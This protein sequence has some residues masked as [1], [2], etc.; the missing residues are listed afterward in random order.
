MLIHALRIIFKKIVE[1]GVYFIHH[2]L[3]VFRATLFSME[4]QHQKYAKT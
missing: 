1:T 2:V 4:K 3:K